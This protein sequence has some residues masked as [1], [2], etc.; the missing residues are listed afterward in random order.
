MAGSPWRRAFLWALIAV[1][2]ARLLLSAWALLISAIIPVGDLAAQYSYVGYPL[3]GGSLVA[4]W[5]QQDA[6][7]YEKIADWG[8]APQNGTT[9][10]FVLLPLL[11]RLVSPLTLGNM[12]AAGM[13][14]G[15]LAALVAFTLL[16]RLAEAD[17][18]SATAGRTLAY[19]ALFPTAFFLYA[20]FT[21][22]LFLALVLGAFWTL[23]RGWWLLTAALALLAGLTKIQG[24]FLGLPLVVE[25]LYLCGW[26]PQWRAW[27]H[28]WPRLGR[29][30]WGIMIVLASAGALATEAFFLYL[31]EVVRDPLGYLAGQTILSEQHV[32]LPWVT[33]GMS[34]GKF[35][36]ESGITI[37]KFDLVV[38]LLFSGLTLAALRFRLSYGLYAITILASI[39]GHANNMFPLMSSTRY[40][41]VAFPCFLVLA[42]GVGRLPRWVHL[43]IIS[44][45]I[46]FMLIWV[47]VFIHGHWV[48]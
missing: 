26:R 37:N 28:A 1:M 10:F 3:Q 38:T 40:L 8:Y 17:S 48:A 41:L 13:L 42:Y 36:S 11:M 31:T 21:E 33:L 7:W 25:Y 5:E 24:A 46:S 44:C 23:R 22:S 15:T 45:W 6:L 39:W 35:V 4:P 9:R 47:M 34:L 32:S 30:Q 29:R 18:D 43:G 16:Y 20:A 2:G 12:A 27:S 14:V 19:L